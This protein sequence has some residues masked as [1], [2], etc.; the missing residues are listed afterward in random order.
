[1]SAILSS[2]VHMATSPIFARV[3]SGHRPPMLIVA[4][5]VSAAVLAERAGFEPAEGC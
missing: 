1:V 4:A 3:P 2:P 5:S